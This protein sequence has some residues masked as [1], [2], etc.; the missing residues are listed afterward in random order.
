MH[1][2]TELHAEIGTTESV[3]K[4]QPAHFLVFILFRFFRSL[5]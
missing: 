3:A 4:A 2:H 1:A 5:R